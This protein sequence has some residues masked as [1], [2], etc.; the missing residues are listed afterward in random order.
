MNF[1]LVGKYEEKDLF[2]LFYLFINFFWIMQWLVW[3]EILLHIVEA[4]FMEVVPFIVLLS[5]VCA[6]I[7]FSYDYMKPFV[8]PKHY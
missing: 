5:A 1:S 3:L 6:V 2:F 7:S 4:F 8:S